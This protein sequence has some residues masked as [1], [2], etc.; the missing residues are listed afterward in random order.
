MPCALCEAPETTDVP[1]SGGP[2]ATI[3]LCERCAAGVAGELGDP[4]HWFC[5]QGSIW[6]EEPAVQVVSWRLLKQLQD[7]TWA[8]DLLEQAYLDDAVLEWARTRELRVVDSNG[9][10]LANGDAVT[11]IKDLDV[12]GANFTAKRG[13]LVKSIRLGDDPEL[14]EGKV[15]GTSIY[16]KTVFLKKV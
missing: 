14:V 13:T 6:S 1:V 3:E 8:S 10:A 12:K 5:L 9:T 4:S 7:H 2:D 11:L 15:N 16:L